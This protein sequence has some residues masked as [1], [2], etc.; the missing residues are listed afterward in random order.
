M[1]EAVVDHLEAI[2]IEIQR[3]EP[4]AALLALELGE[5]LSEPLHEHRAVAQP[6]ERIAEAGV[7]QLLLSR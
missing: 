1:T 3:R 2:E 6:G 5:P 4:V 7:A